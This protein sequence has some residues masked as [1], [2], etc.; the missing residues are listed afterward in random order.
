MINQAKKPQAG[1][2]PRL[3]PLEASVKRQQNAARRVQR[4]YRT[5]LPNL[6][7]LSLAAPVA[8][9]NRQ[10]QSQASIISKGGS[11]V[12]RHKE[13]VVNILGQPTFT[14]VPNGNGIGGAFNFPIQPGSPI[15]FPWLSTIAQNFEQ[16]RF[17][18][19]VAR[20]VP[21]C[22]TGTQ[23]SILLVPDYDAA[24]PAPP[25][26][27]AASNNQDM[28]ED[29]CWR[30][31]EC[32]LDISRMFPAKD[33]FKYVRTGSP[34]VNQDVKTYDGGNL[35][36][37]TSDAA[38]NNTVFGKL[39]VEY[40][41][42]FK[43]PQVANGYTAPANSWIAIAGTTGTNQL[44]VAPGVVNGT[45]PITLVGTTI[46]FPSAGRYTVLYSGSAATSVTA[47]SFVAAG[48]CT[49]DNSYYT[50]F[51]GNLMLS[52]NGSTAMSF[53]AVVNVTVAGA[54]LG[55]GSFTISG[56]GTNSWLLINSINPTG[57]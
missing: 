33:Q 1:R 16:Y 2:R 20:Y 24:D 55:V 54:T 18:K 42:E 27:Q 34:G 17:R 35:W 7:R 43:T 46:T 19:L 6:D 4:E 48:G 3:G 38:A 9:S 52:G 57:N 8:F 36:L 53:A 49:L 30:S 23:G 22:G 41:V 39:W 29:V 13:F 26:E 14:A 31:L 25:N 56:T 44:I 45:L 11:T 15:M 21:R 5:R 40:E 50:N 12:I 32:H 28:S 51:S 10:T 47:S 37:F